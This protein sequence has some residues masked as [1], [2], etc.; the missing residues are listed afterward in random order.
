V[1]I[2]DPLTGSVDLAV[3]PSTLAPGESGTAT[4]TYNTTQDDLNAGEILNTA[5]ATGSDPGGNP[6]QDTDDETIVGQQN[7]A[8]MLLKSAD[9]QV[10]SSVGE[11]ITY[12]FTVTNTGN[13]TLTDVEIDDALTGSVD[14]A[15]TPATLA[16]GASG[17]ATATFTTT[18]DNINSGQILNTATATGK[19]PNGVSVQ[20]EDDETV[21]GPKQEPEIT[22]VK[23]ADPQLYYNVG[24][25][26]IYT[27]TATN[28]G[29]VTLTNVVINDPLTRTVEKLMTPSTLAPGESA[30]ASATY[31]ITQ[32][33][34]DAGQVTNVATVTGYDPDDNP[35]ENEDDE[36]VVDPNQNPAI[37]LEKTADPLVFTEVGELITYTFTVTNTGDVTL[38]N[39][40]IDDPLTG[41]VDLPVT[42]STLAPGASGTAT[43]T[44]NTTQADVNAGIVNN[45]ATATG[46]PPS[47]LD[48]SDDDSAAVEGPKQS[49]DITLIKTA[50]PQVYTETGEVI[51]FTFTVTN[52]GNVTLTDVVI[53]DPLTGSVNLSVSPSTLAPGATGTAM[54]TYTITSGDV[55]SGQVVNV[56]NATGYDPSD[57]SVEDTDEETIEGP[58]QSPDINLIKTAS[59]QTYNEVGDVITYTF[60][61]TNTG[62]ATL[63]NVVIDDPLTGSVNLAVSPSTLDPGETGT[64]TATYT[65]TQADIT[66]GKVTNSAT[67][68]GSSGGEEYSDTDTETVPKEVDPTPDKPSG[69]NET[70]LMSFIDTVLTL[71]CKIGFRFSQCD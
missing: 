18:Q 50:N 9:P 2:D 7:P 35:V 23:T 46:T 22:L 17:T 13:V 39:V 54:A 30:T 24:D 65:I 6:V 71:L 10:Y 32:A 36:V 38:T 15:V 43:A 20:D 41:S 3:T 64:A 67:A 26:I 27:F 66:A 69:G 14:L 57:N 12:T 60:T 16:P 52:T 59:P 21:E 68:T 47:G 45:T 55:S 37:S 44:Y 70:N 48:V 28:T 51:T 34:M 40:V 31:T 8:I 62:N 63:T 42:P 56:A 19:D 53:D 29:N 1:N 4:A 61:V 49:P 5:T 11:T 33:D 58:K 25:I